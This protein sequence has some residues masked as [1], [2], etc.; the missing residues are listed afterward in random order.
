MTC[1]GA[2]G[3]LPAH[4]QESPNLLLDGSPAR[5]IPTSPNSI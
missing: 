5:V 3:T 4:T 2:R 1:I